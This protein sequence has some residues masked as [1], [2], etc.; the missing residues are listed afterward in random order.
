MQNVIL[1][2]PFLPSASDIRAYAGQYSQAELVRQN[3]IYARLC[4]ENSLQRDE[5][6]IVGHLLYTQLGIGPEIRE[7]GL[8][9]ASEW[10]RRADGLI[11]FVDLGITQTMQNAATHARLV[12]TEVSRRTLY[13]L[14]PSQVREILADLVLKDWPHLEALRERPSAKLRAV[15]PIRPI[16]REDG[17]GG[18]LKN[19]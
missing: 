10:M 5:A 19:D 12:Q 15:Q 18:I 13:R 3:L 4:L 1:E 16:Q 17:S 11:L 2:S 7:R 9:A 14:Q 8:K 6:P